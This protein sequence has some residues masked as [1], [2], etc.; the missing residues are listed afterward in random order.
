MLLLHSAGAALYTLVGGQ[1][2]WVLVREKSGG[3]GL[4]KG[5]VEPGETPMQ[6]AL[7]EIREE[8]GIQAEIHREI[9]PLRDTYRLASGQMK[10]VVYYLATY[11]DQP[12]RPDPT[13]VREAMLLPLEDALHALTHESAKR[14]LRKAAMQLPRNIRSADSATLST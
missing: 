12:L 8:T 6:A 11:Q 4:P 2:H 5:H 9:E 14:I 10:R 13:Q 1:P 7:R 3:I